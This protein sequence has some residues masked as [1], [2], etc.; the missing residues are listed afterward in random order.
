MPKHTTGLAAGLALLVTALLAGPVQAADSAGTQRVLPGLKPDL[1]AHYDFGHPVPGAPAEE[2]DQGFSGTDIQLVGGGPA[3]RVPDAAHPGAGN[4][5]QTAQINPG[6]AGNDD[7]KAGLYAPGGVPTLNAF[8]AAKGTTVM[9]WFKMTGDNPAPDSNTPDPDD[10][11]GAIGL[12]GVLAG[13]SDGHGVRALLE[14]IEVEGELRVVALG[15]RLDDGASQTF[16]AAAD[17]RSVLP[18]DEWVH[19]AATF[20]YSD[21]SMAL[22]RNGERLDG[23]YAT[24]GDPWEV[25]GPGDHRASPTDPAGIKIGGSFPQNTRERNP[26]NCRMDDLMFLDRAVSAAEVRQQHRMMTSQQP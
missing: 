17:W 19:L 18:Q 15:R 1:V 5:L 25:E 6:A 7:W 20:D 12:T 13:N 26:C 9:G 16:A 2:Q 10:R 8:N 23:F 22:F 11:Y 4:A 3:M 24:P 21:G 14:L